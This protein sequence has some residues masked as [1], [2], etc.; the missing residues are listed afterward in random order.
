MQAQVTK[1]CIGYLRKSYLFTK[2][3]EERGSK[4]WQHS[5]LRCL[6]N[7]GGNYK[8]MRIVLSQ[9]SLKLSITRIAVTWMLSWDITQVLSSVA[10]STPRWL[11]DKVHARKLVLVITF[12]LLASH[13]LGQDLASPC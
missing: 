8:L 4:T 10:S 11:F 12:L 7:K 5:M 1:V 6:V 9:E 13:G 2:I 3:M